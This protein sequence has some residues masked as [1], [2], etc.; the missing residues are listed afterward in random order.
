MK[1]TIMVSALCFLMVLLIG[2][3]AAADQY[4]LEIKAYIDHID[5]LYVEDNTLQWYWH[6]QWTE[7]GETIISTWLN[8][9]CQ[10]ALKIDP[11]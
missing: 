7:A 4:K 8:G 10:S 5:T 2:T 9:N 3:N 11:L 6:G 1:R